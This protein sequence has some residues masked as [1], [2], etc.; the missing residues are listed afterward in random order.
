MALVPRDARFFIVQHTKTEKNI[1]NG[2]KICQMTTKYAKWPQNM[3][4]GH[5]IYIP[6]GRK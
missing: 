5:K 3:P 4:N 6:N 1:P 2:H